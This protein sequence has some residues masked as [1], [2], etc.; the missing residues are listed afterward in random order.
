M[1]DTEPT[2]GSLGHMHE[3]PSGELAIIAG[4]ENLNQDK[5]RVYTG[6]VN[7]LLCAHMARVQKLTD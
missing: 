3:C 2:P 4:F 6:E 7:V 5:R 1:S